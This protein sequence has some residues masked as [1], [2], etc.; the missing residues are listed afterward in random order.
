MCTLRLT[1]FSVVTVRKP[2][3]IFQVNVQ[4]YLTKGAAGSH[5]SGSTLGDMAVTS[6]LD[7]SVIMVFN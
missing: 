3:G 1:V 4:Y 2:R 7:N 6:Q 5:L